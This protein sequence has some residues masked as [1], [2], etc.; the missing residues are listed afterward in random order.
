MK[1]ISSILFFALYA[2][3]GSPLGT[4]LGGEAG[5]SDTLDPYS[6]HWSGWGRGGLRIV[7]SL[8]GS[9]FSRDSITTYRREN[10]MIA[11]CIADT[12]F[13]QL[14][15]G[16][17][18]SN[19]CKWLIGGIKNIGTPN[20]ILKSSAS[21]PV[22]SQFQDNGTNVSLGSAPISQEHFAIPYT[23]TNSSVDNFY[24]LLTSNAT[25][26]GTYSASGLNLTVNSS[27]D[28]GMA[29]SGTLSGFTA[30]ARKTSG[31]GTLNTIN[32]AYIVYGNSS[33]GT[34]ET[35]T[36]ISLT[37]QYS[38]GIINT[39]YGIRIQPVTGGTVSAAYPIYSQWD[40]PSW[41]MGK[42]LIG[43]SS[44]ITPKADL[45]IVNEDAGH[46][47]KRTLW[48]SGGSTSGG[49]GPSI[50]FNPVYGAPGTYSTW[51]GGEI[52]CPWDGLSGWSGQMIFRVNTGSDPTNLENVMT[53][54][55][56]KT[57]TLSNYG[58]GY[59]K[60]SSAGILSS[61]AVPDTAL[62][63]KNLGGYPMSYHDTVGHGAK[64][65]ATHRVT[66]NY[67]PYS[68][69]TTTW[70]TAPMWTNGS[71]I[72]IGNNVAGSLLTLY[73]PTAANTGWMLQTSGSDQ[74]SGCDLYQVGSDCGL[75]F[76]GYKNTV[77]SKNYLWVMN[78]GL[79]IGD[80]VVYAGQKLQ[81]YD[82]NPANVGI[83][84]NAGVGKYA[85]FDLYQE[86][87]DYGLKFYGF[88]G[89]AKY[90][91][92]LH[93]N[94]N[95]E[96][97]NNLTVIKHI[98]GRSIYTDTSSTGF[99]GYSTMGTIFSTGNISTNG[100]ITASMGRVTARS[101]AFDSIISNTILK[102][103]AINIKSNNTNQLLGGPQFNYGNN[104]ASSG[105]WTDDTIHGFTQIISKRG[106]LTNN[107]EYDLI[108]YVDGNMIAGTLQICIHK[109]GNPDS[110]FYAVVQIIPDY[111]LGENF[112]AITDY[113]NPG[114]I[115]TTGGDA[116]YYNIISSNSGKKISLHNHRGASAEVWYCFIGS[117]F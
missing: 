82:A 25:S 87:S 93:G 3:A 2:I 90:C 8:T 92:T 59:I 30:F 80:S 111:F 107:G 97:L 74:Y 71:K 67:F 86:G 99:G 35:A 15:G 91:Q 63:A 76:W 40:F 45:H 23:I 64:A 62:G 112:I 75:K 83:M 36:G 20:Y 49:D 95:I 116:G 51:E 18:N 22:N 68:A 9:H 42:L 57:V 44:Y 11:F 78:N 27:V 84:L 85:G 117:N 60:S 109:P 16:I 29:N 113:K 4:N 19:W 96:I 77:G 66:P 58:A 65:D 105:T 1:T 106:T 31:K 10:A 21:G 103:P 34:V 115:S 5:P 70:G 37:P 43:N 94:G 73:N 61:V 114:I 47:L 101:A 88:S 110:T 52:G 12:S 6:T 53:L 26:S 39:M 7:P 89:G 54:N 69:S 38:A 33:D 98:E 46:G 24:S 81:L 14:V 56:N 32:S 100:N 17:E 79:T 108:N 72:T 41:L 50:I 104:V 48:L 55:S 28:D 13:Y 102:A